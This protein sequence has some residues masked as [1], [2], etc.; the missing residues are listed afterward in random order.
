ML[1]GVDLSHDRMGTYC[2]GT[3]A[4]QVFMEPVTH[5]DCSLCRRPALEM[6]FLTVIF[7]FLS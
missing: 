3:N 1:M 7:D 4:N 5:T 6:P 2:W